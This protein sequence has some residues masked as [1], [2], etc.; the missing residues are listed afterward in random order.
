VAY[1][2]CRAFCRNVFKEETFVV[3]LRRSSGPVG[4][5]H[6]IFAAGF[7]SSSSAQ[8]TSVT[9][10]A[11]LFFRLNRVDNGHGLAYTPPVAQ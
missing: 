5:S 11:D 9:N 2:K 1:V 4:H 3:L 6:F 8:G 7:L 10:A